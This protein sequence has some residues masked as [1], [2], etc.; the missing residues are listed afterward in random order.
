M[1][2]VQREVLPNISHI[3]GLSHFIVWV[4]NGLSRNSIVAVLLLWVLLLGWLLWYISKGSPP[5][6]YCQGGFWD[7]LRA[8][9]YRGMGGYKLQEG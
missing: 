7:C 6:Y 9:A 8:R 4:R 5:Q 1:V 3:I 2:Y